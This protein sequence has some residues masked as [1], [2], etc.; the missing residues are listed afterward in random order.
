MNKRILTILATG[1]VFAALSNGYALTCAKDYFGYS[2]FVPSLN[3]DAVVCLPKKLCQ[4][5]NVKA[6][7]K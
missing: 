5:P 1:F 6:Q 7:L 3:D 4:L 2:V